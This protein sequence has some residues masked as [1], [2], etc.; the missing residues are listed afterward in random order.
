[1]EKTSTNQTS[2]P[3]PERKNEVHVVGYLKEDTLELV[4]DAK[5]ESIRGS[6]VIAI[7][8]VNSYKVQYF[9]RK[10]TASGKPSKNFENLE[11]LLPNNVITVASY[12][13]NNPTASFAVAANGASKVWARGHLE[14]YANMKDGKE[15]TSVIIK[16]EGAGF[17][18]ITDRVPFDPHANFNCEVY[19]E[20]IAPEMKRASAEDSPEETGRLILTGLIPTYDGSMHRIP[21]IAPAEDGVAAH[22]GEFYEAGQTARIEGDLV[23]VQV[24]REAA[25]SG[26]TFGRVRE[27]QPRASFYKERLI[28]GGDRQPKGPEDPGAITPEV[29]KD[30][31]ATRAA[32]IAESGDRKPVAKGFTSATPATAPTTTVV[33]P[34]SFS[35]FDF[36]DF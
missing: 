15:H 33:T 20:K 35:D 34:E 5:G 9:A 18:S 7:D 28:R 30:G 8:E 26:N 32:K 16:G 17:K 6:I 31:L 3:K 11:K 10:T 29:V 25:S 22:I 23:T 21:F 27:S 12:L 36:N 19:I 14:E 24:I 4:K 1:M 2:T 13:A